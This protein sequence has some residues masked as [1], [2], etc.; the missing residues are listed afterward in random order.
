MVNHSCVGETLGEA[1]MESEEVDVYFCAL[2][3]ELEKRKINKPVRLA[4][5]G[6]IYMMFF[7]KNRE[8]TKDVDVIPLDFP[9]TTEPNQETKAFRSAINAVARRY[10][11]RRDWMNDVVA[12]FTQELGALTLWRE[13]SNLQI[14]VPNAECILVL[15]LLAGRAKD[16]DDIL[17]L[18]DMLDIQTR[19]QAQELVDR[20]ADKTWQKECVLEKTL[21]DLF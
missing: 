11:L 18:C 10:Q 12:A 1:G 6:G 4:V 21:D 15:K 16:E 13:Y 14:Y 8:S 20:Y 9:D 5:V 19:E 17:A 3:E 2:D 7:L